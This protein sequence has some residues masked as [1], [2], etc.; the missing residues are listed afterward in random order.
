MSFGVSVG[1]FIAVGRL[2]GGISVIIKDTKNGNNEY[3]ELQRELNSLDQ[4]LKSLD[5]LQPFGS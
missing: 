4:A 2:I 3:Q 5:R 1:D